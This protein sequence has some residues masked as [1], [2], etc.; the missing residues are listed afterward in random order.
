MRESRFLAILLDSLLRGN[1]RMASF[2][3]HSTYDDLENVLINMEDSLELTSISVP[4]GLTGTKVMRIKNGTKESVIFTRAVKIK[5]DAVEILNICI[6]RKERVILTFIA[7]EL[8]E[9]R[10]VSSPSQRTSEVTACDYNK[11][12]GLLVRVRELVKLNSES[13]E[14][15]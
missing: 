1:D 10:R 5:E 2:V 4:P 11:A 15:L 3:I 8:T 14:G 6:P 13:H 7:D 12:Y 9:L